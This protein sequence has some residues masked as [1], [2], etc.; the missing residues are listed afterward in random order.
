MT[1]RT[2]D[3][4]PALERDRAHTDA[5]ATEALACLADEAH[6]GPDRVPTTDHADP[7]HRL[8]PV[9]LGADSTRRVDEHLKLAGDVADVCERADN[10]WPAE[11]AGCSA[12]KA[13]DVLAA[14]RKYEALERLLRNKAHA[15]VWARDHNRRDDAAKLGADI[16]R[17]YVEIGKAR[18]EFLREVSLAAPDHAC[19]A[20][21]SN[22]TTEME[23]DGPQDVDPHLRP[24]GKQWAVRC[25][26]E[27]EHREKL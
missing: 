15:Q 2:A 25:C 6:D 20:C 12:K 7:C 26:V 19:S 22:T 13:Y 3:L 21:G 16:D 11:R 17:L 4:D 8:P 23:D 5:I 27:C 24:R 9:M 14:A 1:P 18:E 10:V